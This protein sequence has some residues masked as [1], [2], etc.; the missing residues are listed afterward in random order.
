MSTPAKV[1]L[2]VVL[3]AAVV[4]SGYLGTRV[5]SAQRASIAAAARTAV[6]ATPSA[7]GTPSGPSTGAKPPQAPQ[8]PQRPQFGPGPRTFGFGGPAAPNFGQRG[9][10]GFNWPQFGPRFGQRGPQGFNGPQFGPRGFS[11]PQFGQ[12]GPGWFPGG[13]RGGFSGGFGGFTDRGPR[14]GMAAPAAGWVSQYRPQIN[15]AMASALGMS[16]ADYDKAIAEGNSPWQIA[17]GKNISAAD[18][19]TK[20][21]D[22]MAQVLK[23]V[24]ADGKLTQAQADAIVARIRQ[25]GAA[26]L[27]W[28]Y[29]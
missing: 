7:P 16:V 22:A 1:G 21:A 8:G 23:Q 27:R 14:G 29:P 6:P 11:G 17:Q 5:A 18:F 2:I 4:G 15:D 24:V 13:R 26:G 20:T 28:I 3:V 10:Q 19:Q 9:P 12:R 25:G